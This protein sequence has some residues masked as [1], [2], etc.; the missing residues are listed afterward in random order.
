MRLPLAALTF[1]LDSGQ[2]FDP[3]DDSILPDFIHP[4]KELK[5]DL[6]K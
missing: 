5:P 1:D 6:T 4:V 2:V 3:P